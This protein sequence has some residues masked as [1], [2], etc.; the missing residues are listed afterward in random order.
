MTPG[1]GASLASPVRSLLATLGT[2]R[3]TAEMSALAR[4]VWRLGES[5]VRVVRQ[6]RFPVEEYVRQTWYAIGVCSL[7]ALAVSIPASTSRTRACSPVP[8][9]WQPAP[10]TEATTPPSATGAGARSRRTS[11]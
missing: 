4:L 10:S 8:T 1:A 11:P 5:T 9:C 7:P 2:N 6:R 3:P